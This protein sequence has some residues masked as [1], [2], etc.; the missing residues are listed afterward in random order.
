MFCFIE[1]VS[2]C[3]RVVSQRGVMNKNIYML[4]FITYEN[5][6]KHFPQLQS[7]TIEQYNT[8]FE[9]N[10]KYYSDLMKCDR[11]SKTP[12]LLNKVA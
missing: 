6:D 7:A 9:K 12:T 8:Q 1:N 4:L 10:Q 11:Y 5:K 2:F 3:A